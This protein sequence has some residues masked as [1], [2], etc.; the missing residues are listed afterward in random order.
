MTRE[1]SP[2][3]ALFGLTLVLL[4]LASAA[5]LFFLRNA[6]PA[7]A[8]P[9]VV[10]TNPFADLP[11]ETPPEKQ[12]LTKGQRQREQQ[13]LEQEELEPEGNAKEK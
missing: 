4:V 1:K 7:Q 6:K 5:A 11:P 13:R 9:E 2:M 3:A 10:E 8:T 12:A